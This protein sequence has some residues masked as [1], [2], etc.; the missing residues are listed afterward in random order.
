L[1]VRI[2][3]KYFVWYEAFCTLI[4]YIL[5]SNPNGDKIT[6]IREKPCRDSKDSEQVIMEW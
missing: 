1:G 6:E 2:F 5:E 4:Y 3:S